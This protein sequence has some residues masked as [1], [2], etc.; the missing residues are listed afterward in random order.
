MKRWILLV[1]GTAMLALLPSVALAQGPGNGDF[2][3]RV[4]SPLVVPPDDTVDTAMVVNAQGTFDGVIENAAVVINGTAVVNGVINGDLTVINGQA[5]LRD[6]ARVQN[7]ALVNSTITQAPGAQVSGQVTRTTASFNPWNFTAVWLVFW[8]GMTVLVVIGGLIFAA[9]GGRQLSA[10][11]E[12]LA[13]RPGPVILAALI[14]G[15]GLPILGIIAFATVIGIPFGIAVFLVLLP[16]IWVI[17]YLV[18]GTTVGAAI[19]RAVGNRTSAEHPYLA[20]VVGLVILQIIGLIPFLGG[21]VVS[22]AGIY[23]AGGATLLAWHAFRTP[24]TRHPERPAGAQAPA[25]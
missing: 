14:I 20:S 4:N 2:L 25:P 11:G 16:A 8:L 17:G 22:L 18:A 15:I 10:A 6:G 9:I 12:F 21:L 7:V 1:L 23:G 13:T 24:R 5:D 19:L 3:L